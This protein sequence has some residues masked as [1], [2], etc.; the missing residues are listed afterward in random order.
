MGKIV[1]LS[2]RE[3][4]VAEL[5]AW[6]AAQK[7]VADYLGISARTVS[8]IVTS[9]YKKLHI[10]KVSELCVWYF[11]SKFNISLDLSPIVRRGLAIILLC[12]FIPTLGHSSEY[13]RGR[14]IRLEVR[15]NRV[16]EL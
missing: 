9:L 16:E 12:I 11:T 5:L 4:E 8:N 13:L 2:H 10:Q 1:D 6:G 3:Y 7:E 15:R 14:T